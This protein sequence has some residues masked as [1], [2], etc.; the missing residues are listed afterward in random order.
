MK[1]F[2]AADDCAGLSPRPPKDF[3]LLLLLPPSFM[4]TRPRQLFQLGDALL[5]TSIYHLTAARPGISLVSASISHLILGIA[6]AS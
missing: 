6:C 4:S 5:S 3:L 1:L 2:K